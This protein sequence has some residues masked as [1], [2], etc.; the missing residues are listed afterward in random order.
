MVEEHNSYG[1]V[2]DLEKPQKN[3]YN[4]T[5]ADLVIDSSTFD[6]TNPSKRPVGWKE[7]RTKRVMAKE[8]V[9]NVDPRIPEARSQREQEVCILIMPSFIYNLNLSEFVNA[10]VVGRATHGE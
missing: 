7:L 6:P 10:C 4:L 3:P 2:F 1:V 8:R 5:P 9:T